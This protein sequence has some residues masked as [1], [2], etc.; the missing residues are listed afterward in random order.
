MYTDFRQTVPGLDDSCW[1]TLRV[2]EQCDRAVIVPCPLTRAGALR[3]QACLTVAA[4]QRLA[5]QPQPPHPH[6]RLHD[7][8]GPPPSPLSRWSDSPYHGSTLLGPDS[9]S[10]PV[11]TL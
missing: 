3:R 4:G 11:P 6:R 9:R 8:Q 2:L 7:P 10:E 1:P 5:G